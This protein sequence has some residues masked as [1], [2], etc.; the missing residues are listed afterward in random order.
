M[1]F[2]SHHTI[3]RPP[4]VLSNR[5]RLNTSQ[6]LGLFSLSHNGDEQGEA[7]SIVQVDSKMRILSKII[8]TTGWSPIGKALLIHIDETACQTL[9]DKTIMGTLTDLI[10]NNIATITLNTSIQISGSEVYRIR[11]Y[12]RHKGFDFYRLPFGFIAADL[13]VDVDGLKDVSQDSLFAIASI[14]LA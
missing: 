5:L 1:G 3:Q 11:A 10:S 13:A 2:H 9:V 12:T 14:K 4:F 8:A 7:P 6:A